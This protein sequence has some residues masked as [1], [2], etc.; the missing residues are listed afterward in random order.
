MRR[1]IRRIQIAVALVRDPE[2]SF[3]VRRAWRAAEEAPPWQSLRDRGDASDR[4]AGLVPEGF[5]VLGIGIDCQK[6]FVVWQI[7]VSSQPLTLKLRARVV[8]KS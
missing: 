5:P 2:L 8:K 1:L 3:T 4:R 6:D 7:V